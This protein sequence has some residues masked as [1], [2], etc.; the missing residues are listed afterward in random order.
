MTE[1]E[2][3]VPP[4]N[5]DPDIPEVN[6]EAP[7]SP[8]P[9]ARPAAVTAVGY[10]LLVFALI[11]LAALV[12]NI[13]QLAYLKQQAVGTTPAYLWSM[14]SVSLVSM[15]CTALAGYSVLNLTRWARVGTILILIGLLLF[16]VIVRGMMI[17]NIDPSLASVAPDSF[18]AGALKTSRI[19]SLATDLFRNLLIYGALISALNQAAVK[20]AF[21]GRGR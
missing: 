7:A 20:A 6:L 3:T 19:V 16:E 1:I 4:V 9:A 18:N 5:T 21:G 12:N 2:Q 8:E 10:I 15:I 17:N 11:Y 13:I 14:L